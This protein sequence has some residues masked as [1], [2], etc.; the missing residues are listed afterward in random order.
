MFFIIISVLAGVSIVTA[1]TLNSLLASKIG[2]F[3]S[4]FWNYVV[5]LIF[6]FA[7]M[8]ASKEVLQISKVE[9]GEIPLWAYT[10]GLIGVIVVMLSNYITLKISAIYLTLLLFVGQL[11]VAIIIDYIYLDEMSAGK[12]L[13]GILVFLGLAYNLLQ[14]RKPGTEKTS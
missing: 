4:T 7:F 1:R 13:G 11:L 6:S 3:Q 10:G 5:G 2:V 12:V 9:Y 14:D 8:L